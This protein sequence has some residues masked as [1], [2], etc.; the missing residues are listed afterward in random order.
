MTASTRGPAPFPFAAALAAA[1]L[2]GGLFPLVGCSALKSPAENAAIAAP[3]EPDAADSDAAGS[4]EKHDQAAS[5]YRNRAAPQ[6]VG[7]GLSDEAR[8]I[9]RSLGYK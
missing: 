3:T 5:A 2:C 7:T 6:G 4:D 9:E 1:L 8:D